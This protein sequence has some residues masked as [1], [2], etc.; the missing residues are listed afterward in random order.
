MVECSGATS[1]VGVESKPREKIEIACLAHLLGMALTAIQ[2]GNWEAHVRITVVEE[3]AMSVIKTSVDTCCPRRRQL[4]AHPSDA[5]T[6]DSATSAVVVHATGA[7]AVFFD[8]AYLCDRVGCVAS[9]CVYQD[10]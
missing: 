8:I 9:A 2:Y 1:Q 10:K 7:S 5:S 4:R 6:A 3:A